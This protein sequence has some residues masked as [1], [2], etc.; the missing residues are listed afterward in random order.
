MQHSFVHRRCKWNILTE[1]E[2]NVVNGIQC[3]VRIFSIQFYPIKT[4]SGIFPNG[5]HASCSVHSIRH[6]WVKMQ[7]KPRIKSNKKSFTHKNHR[8]NECFWTQY[9]CIVSMDFECW[10]LSAYEGNSS[11][12]VKTKNHF[13]LD[14]NLKIKCMW[15]V[16]GLFILLNAER[17]MQVQT[18]FGSSFYLFII[19]A[20]IQ[21]F[22]S[23]FP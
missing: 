8:L 23:M 20:N 16:W 22:I 10:M 1:P 13:F 3:W 11:N 9:K 4:N 17:S 15:T 2:L 21:Q 6:L 14:L 12:F 7:P 19:S 18:N 5:I